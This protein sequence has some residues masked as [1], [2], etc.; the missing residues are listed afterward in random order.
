M[1]DRVKAVAREL[2]AL[3]A[4]VQGNEQASKMLT[5][6]CQ[7]AINVV[8]PGPAVIWKMMMQPH[9]NACLRVALELGLVEALIASDGPKSAGELAD[10]VRA[11]QLLV[12]FKNP[13][14]PQGSF[15]YAHNSP[16][17]TFEWLRQHPKQLTDFNVFMAGQ[18][19][20][21]VD[22][23]DAF[24]VQDILFHGFQ[25]IND[26]VLLVDIAGGRG[27]DLEAFRKRFPDAFGKLILEDLPAAIDEIEHLDE[28]ILRMKYDFF[29]P[30][31]V[32][33]ARAYYF[34][35]IFHNWTDSKCRD[36][37][38][39]VVKAM[40][41]GYSKLLVNE[42]VL[43]EAGVPL[44]PALLDINMMALFSGMQR[45]QTQ[46]KDLLE[47]VG[48]KIVKFW[49]V[50]PEVEGLIEAVVEQEQSVA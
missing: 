47:S 18:R 19:N 3:T 1:Q 20:S 46:W 22:W 24:P 17:P 23:F 9:Q 8:T 7:Q 48:L 12:G 45:T 26:E 50:G 14:G 4:Q 37:L 49:S 36:I 27:H 31:P 43:P 44:Y 28:S 32:I 25:R 34:R 10:M 35:A 11:D 38:Q 39:N 21:R 40:K 15:Q 16:L 5:E 30:Q 29:T 33:G 41:P 13:E 42:W 6:A 2:E